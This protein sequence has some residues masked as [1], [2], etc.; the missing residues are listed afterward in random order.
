MENTEMMEKI[1]EQTFR[2]MMS[3]VVR[4]ELLKRKPYLTEHE[5][6]EMTGIAV[7]TLQTRRSRGLPPEY[8]KQGKSIF[9]KNE[10][11]QK[12]MDSCSVIIE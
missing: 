11:I 4:L 2:D 9:Y 12:Y 5:V 7:K 10:A 1:M 3:P 8:I 6:S